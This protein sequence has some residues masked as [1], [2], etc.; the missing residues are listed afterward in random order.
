[1]FY[2][3][4]LILHILF[5][6]CNGSC[7]HHAE[8]NRARFVIVI[9]T[10][11][12]FHLLGQ[13]IHYMY[14]VNCR[15]HIYMIHFALV[16]QWVFSRSHFTPNMCF[17][18]CLKTEDWLLRTESLHKWLNIFLLC[19]FCLVKIYVLIFLLSFLI[20]YFFF[21]VFCCSFMFCIIFMFVLSMY[22]CTLSVTC[23]F[24]QK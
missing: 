3:F 17:D 6:I 8:D 22:A 4:C 9:Q 13:M 10:G 11:P 20:F 21:F 2:C 24:D 16:A 18:L 23:R 5:Y 12:Q 19:Y 1:M 14:I 7:V 15:Y